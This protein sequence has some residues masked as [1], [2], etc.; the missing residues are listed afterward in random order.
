[1]GRPPGATNGLIHTGKIAGVEKK[2]RDRQAKAQ[3]IKPRTFAAV[4][5]EDQAERIA[6]VGRRTVAHD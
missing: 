6:A 5:V 2:D 1:M 3:K 4:A